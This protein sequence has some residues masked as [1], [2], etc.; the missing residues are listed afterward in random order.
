VKVLGL[1]GAAVLLIV[2]T[3]PASLARDLIVRLL[4]ASG[5]YFAASAGRK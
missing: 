5:I 4:I 1:T 3:T 2:A